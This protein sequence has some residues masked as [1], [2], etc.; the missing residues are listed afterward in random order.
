MNALVIKMG[1]MDGTIPEGWSLDLKKLP[2]EYEEIRQ[3]IKE[4]LK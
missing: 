2:P 1:Q 3:Y 4:N